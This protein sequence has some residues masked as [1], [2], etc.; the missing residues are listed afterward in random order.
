MDYFNIPFEQAH[1]VQA[2]WFML[3][4]NTAHELRMFKSS[5]TIANTY[6]YTYI[7][8]VSTR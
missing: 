4:K 7:D 2:Q 8:T 1:L 6:V 3:N 5:V